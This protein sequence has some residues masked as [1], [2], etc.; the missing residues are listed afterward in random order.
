MIGLL[1]LACARWRR[2]GEGDLPPRPR[3]RAD[4][5]ERSAT[6]RFEKV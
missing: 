1:S 3:P 5:L 2:D 4:G 6:G